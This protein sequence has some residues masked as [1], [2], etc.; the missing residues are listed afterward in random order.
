MLRSMILAL[1]ALAV[2]SDA[3]ATGSGMLYQLAPDT[4]FEAG[5]FAPCMCPVLIQASV[6]GTF[7]LVPAGFDGL[8][9]HYDVVDVDWRFPSGDA[10]V[11]V[12]GS[13]R[14][15]VGGEVAVQQQMTLD[16]ALDGGPPGTYDSGL[17][18]GGGQFPAIDVNVA[19]HGFFCRDTAFHVQGRPT[20]TGVDDTPGVA[21]LR[22]SPNPFERRT[23]I[24]FAM[25][26]AG[27]V[28][29]AV[30]ELAGRRIRTLVAG[31]RYGAGVQRLTW[32]GARDDGSRAGGGIYFVVVRTPGRE[33]RAAVVKIGS[34]R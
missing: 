10:Q 21:R 6:T 17:V 22:A 27:P 11:H 32:D 30:H 9:Q 5:C 23:E 28:F 33:M 15:K 18:A 26:E 1:A 2:F 20:T 3:D 29:V 24:A 25:P 19:L 13:G 4:G 14:Y 31:G 12:T 7:V 8:Y 34:A 16:L